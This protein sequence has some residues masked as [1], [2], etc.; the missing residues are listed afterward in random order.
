MEQWRAD[1]FRFAR[2]D[3]PGDGYILEKSTGK[4]STEHV[5]ISPFRHKKRAYSRDD[6]TH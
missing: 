5:E 4:V 2:K 3:K 6:R 1:T